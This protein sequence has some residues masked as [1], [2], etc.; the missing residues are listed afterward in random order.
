MSNCF[1]FHKY[2]WVQ[3][4]NPFNCYRKCSKCGKVQDLSYSPHI[5]QKVGCSTICIRCGL[6]N[7]T[8]HTFVDVEGKCL[9]RC[10]VCGKEE[11]VGHWMKGRQKNGL[12]EQYCT[13]CGFTIEGHMWWD[14]SSFGAYYTGDHYFKSAGCRCVIC[15]ASNPNGV[16]KWKKITEEQYTGIKVCTVCGARD[17][18]EKITL[19][20]AS[21]RQ[22]LAN[23]ERDEAMRREDSLSEM[24]SVGIKC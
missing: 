19:E 22:A 15:G 8:E 17:E 3:S 7:K 24:R 1:L 14:D 18:S 16:H 2:E 12:C 10:T 20:E 23:A 13:K 21:R 11:T 4:A 5:F 6:V 9:R